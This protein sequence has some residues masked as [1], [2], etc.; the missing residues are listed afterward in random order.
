MTLSVWKYLLIHSLKKNLLCSY[1]MPCTGGS[2][3]GKI[4]LLPLKSPLSTEGATHSEFNINR[5]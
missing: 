1:Y 5:K 3:L 2:V 4:I